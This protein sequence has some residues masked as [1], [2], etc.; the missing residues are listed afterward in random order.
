MA[1]EGIV[2]KA[3]FPP[4][5]KL[6]I[7][8]N[9]LK[10]SELASL[11]GKLKYEENLID[12]IYESEKNK[13]LVST[14]PLSTAFFST[15]IIQDFQDS[16]DDE[17][18][19]ISS[20]EYLNDLEEEYQARALLAKSKRFYKKGT[21]SQYTDKVPSNESQRNTIDPSVV[22]FDSSA[23]D[24]DSANESS[25]RSTLLSLKKLDGIEPVSGPK[26]IKSILKSKSTFKAKTLKGITINEASSAPARGKSSLASKTNSAPAG[27]NLKEIILNTNN[28]VALLYPEHNNKDYFKYVSDFISKCCLKKPFTISPNMYK[29]YLAEFWYSAK[30]LENSKVFF[31]IQP[32]GIFGEVRVNTFRNSIGVH[33]LPHSSEYV[34]PSSIDVFRQWFPMIGYEEV[35]SA[36]GTLIKSLF[37]PR[38]RLLMTQ[39]IQ[40][41][42]GKIGGFDPITNKDVII[43]YSLASG[44]R[45]R[46]DMGMMRVTGEARANPQL[47]SGMSAFN[48]NEP[49]YL[50]SLIIHYEKGASTVS[51]QIKEE[52]SNTIKLEDLAKLV[53]HVLPSFKDLDSPK[54]DHVIVVN[55]SDEDEDDEVHATENVELKMLQ[56]LNPYLPGL[57]KFKSLPTKKGPIT[58]KVYR[59]DG[60]SVIIPNFKA[61]DLHL[62]KWREVMKACPN[63][64][65]KGWETNYKQ[66]ANKWIKSSVQYEDHLPG[67]VL[68]E[69][70]LEVKM[71]CF[72]SRR[73]TR[74]EKDCFM[75]KG[76]K[77][78]PW[79]VTSKVG[80]EIHQLSFKECTWYY[81][82]C[83]EIKGLHGVTIAQLVL[84][85]YK[86]TI[87]FNKVNATSSRVTTADR[88]TTAGW[89]KRKID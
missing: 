15:S 78:S 71:C 58:L 17:E 26:T 77:Q 22:V 76:I 10:N 47:S 67:T 3:Y 56:F 87:V 79:N 81:K 9:V 41:L 23:T 20:H 43:L 29:E 68:N 38:W 65:G 85:V 25:V 80:I 37:P 33:Y 36:K 16:L 73:F 59:E 51:N 89:I 72:T 24:Y 2:S 46:K 66:I 39:I 55:D 12:S 84:L 83:V 19:T 64:I 42:G 4:T 44:T 1:I 30:A 8:L 45:C 48:L 62:G 82:A 27:F 60:T 18:D 49:I 69:P 63:R 32:G 7:V 86:V 35:V 14:T 57:L 52:T 34:A 74:Q 53:S 28:E 70:V 13:S 61:S 11:F 75:S 5:L 6:N 40:C 21:Q 88:V 54:D 31:S 50:A